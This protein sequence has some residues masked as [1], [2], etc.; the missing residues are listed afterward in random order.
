MASHRLNDAGGWLRPLIGFTSAA[1]VPMAVPAQLEPGGLFPWGRTVNGEDLFWRMR[2]NPDKWT[3]VAI[4]RAC[5][6]EVFDCS[7]SEFLRQILNQ[8]LRPQFLPPAVCSERTFRRPS[9][10]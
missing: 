5:G 3:V 8:T 6:V 4:G 7:M 1:G 2:G 9:D 10:G